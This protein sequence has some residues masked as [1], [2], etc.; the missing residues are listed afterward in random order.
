[1]T[2]EASTFTVTRYGLDG[3]GIRMLLRNAKIRLRLRVVLTLQHR[4][5]LCYGITLT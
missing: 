3:T 2:S 5:K 1:M 4:L